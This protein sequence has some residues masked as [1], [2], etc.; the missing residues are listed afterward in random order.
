[1]I[2]EKLPN[3]ELEYQFISNEQFDSVINTQLAAGQ[4]PD[5]IEVGAQTKKNLASAG[6]LLDI[7]SEAFTS[8]YHE[9]GLSP[10]VYEARIMP[11]Q[12]YHGLKVYGIT[13]IYLKSII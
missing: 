2:R 3:I 4:G 10:Y 8:R 9:S 6:Y 12:I 1:M 11:Y 13:R 7:S 5:I